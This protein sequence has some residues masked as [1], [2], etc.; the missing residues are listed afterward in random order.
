MNGS[1]GNFLPGP[2]PGFG[3]NDK[4]QVTYTPGG[5][6]GQDGMPTIVLPD[7]EPSFFPVDPGDLFA[8]HTENKDGKESPKK[9]WEVLPGVKLPEFEVADLEVPDLNVPDPTSKEG[10]EMMKIAVQIMQMFGGFG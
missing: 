4:G 8:E 10:Q 3:Q 1:I 9:D 7:S 5:F 2:I 6:A